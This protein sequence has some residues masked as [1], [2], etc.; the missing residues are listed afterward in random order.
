MSFS[1][2]KSLGLWGM[3]VLPFPS[4][5]GLVQWPVSEGAQSSAHADFLCYTCLCLGPST[6]IEVDDEVDFS[7]RPKEGRVAGIDKECSVQQA[8]MVHGPRQLVRES[9]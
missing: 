4:F 2:A 9:I 1:D 7:L 8:Q 5:M 3:R 6:V